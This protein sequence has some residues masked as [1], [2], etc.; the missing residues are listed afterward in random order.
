[1]VV[2]ANV[3]VDDCSVVV[4]VGTSVVVVIPLEQTNGFISAHGE[5]THPSFRQSA[6]FLPTRMQSSFPPKLFGS[7]FIH[8]SISS[9][10]STSS[11][12]NPKSGTGLLPPFSSTY[13]HSESSR[14]DLVKSSI[15]RPLI[16]NW[17]KPCDWASAQIARIVRALV[18]MA[19]APLS[20]SHT[21]CASSHDN[22]SS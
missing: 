5:S 6:P 16:Q 17:P 11:I 4:V 18:T 8:A 2:V 13:S 15:R 22:N 21:A 14:R 19:S 12:P 7:F 1:V 20:A 3:V 9:F 10:P